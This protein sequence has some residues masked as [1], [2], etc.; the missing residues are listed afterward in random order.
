[1]PAIN[2][3]ELHEQLLNDPTVKSLNDQLVSAYQ[4]A[5]IVGVTKKSDGNF[6]LIY[7]KTF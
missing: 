7:H 1:M 6:E 2:G 3:R 4:K 5:I